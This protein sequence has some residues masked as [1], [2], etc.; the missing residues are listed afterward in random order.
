MLHDICPERGQQSVEAHLC[1]VTRQCVGLLAGIMLE[2]D[3]GLEKVAVLACESSAVRVL[4]NLSLLIQSLATVT[5][6]GV[7][8]AAINNLIM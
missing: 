5:P 7:N 1:L 6:E 2:L 4:L 3:E 8:F